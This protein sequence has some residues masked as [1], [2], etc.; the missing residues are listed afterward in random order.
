M[1][2]KKKNTD[3][4]W[5]LK[6]AT[7]SYRQTQIDKFVFWWNEGEPIAYIAEQFGLPMYDI[8][9]LVIHC[10]LDKLIKPRPGG[11]LGSKTHNTKK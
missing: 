6:D 1:G 7:L 8:A 9:L 3:W 10:E 11:L 4:V 5:I 2:R